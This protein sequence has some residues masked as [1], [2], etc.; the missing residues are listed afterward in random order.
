[1]VCLR[2]DSDN[3]PEPAQQSSHHGIFLKRRGWKLRLCCVKV[4]I[5]VQKEKHAK[6]TFEKTVYNFGKITQ[7]D[8]LTATFVFRNTGENIL[9]IDK[10]I[11]DRN[12][13]ASVSSGETLYP[14]EK[15]SIQATLDSSNLTGHVVKRI[16]LATNDPKHKETVL[17][18]KAHVEAILTLDPPFIFVGQLDK[19]ES[20]SNRVKLAGKLADEA[21]LS[22]LT[23]NVSSPSIKAGIEH[24]M[25][26]GKE[27]PFLAFTIQPE[28]KSGNFKEGVTLISKDPPANAKLMLFGLKL[29]DIRV[30]PDKLDFS[31]DDKLKADFRSILLESEKNFRIIKV[32][33]LSGI[34]ATS[35]EVI[36]TGKTYKLLAKIKSESLTQNFLGVVKVYTDLQE[37]PII[38][39]PVIRGSFSFSDKLPQPN[40]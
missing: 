26:E 34:L 21:N 15:G 35:I 23:I 29:G 18:L 22:A 5:E 2:K 33:D 8:V 16:I 36:E 24:R 31:P 32:E 39:I 12:C 40:F 4:R 27:M 17:E 1:L 37:Q 9:N 7:G 25:V 20:Y 19:D 11:A 6:I 3:R 14:G 38:N 13:T 10:V 28:M 30:T